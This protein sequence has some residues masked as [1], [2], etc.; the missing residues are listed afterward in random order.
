MDEKDTNR[1]EAFSD[2]VFAVAI[3]LL[4]LDI[5]FSPLDAEKLKD[6][7]AMWSEIGSQWPALFAFI[8]SFCTIGVMW[9]NH[10]RVFK[11]IKHS[12]TT[13]VFI[14]LLLLMIIVFIPVPTNLLAE[15]INHPEYH[16]AAILYG[17]T[18]L[19]MASC[20]SLLW[21]YASHHGRLLGKDV[22]T[23][24][25]NWISRQYAFGPL[26]Y[27]ISIVLAL[28]Y[29]PVSVAFNFLLGIFFALPGVP[30]RRRNRS[31]PLAEKEALSE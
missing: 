7:V 18:F 2:G 5:K 6:D 1:L 29:P 28:V 30:L 19:A 10:H 24:G 27:V 15:Y 22:D 4:V 11:H 25:V 21:R 20:F 23:H 9:L 17:I 26:L 8:T 14:N 31:G 3:T 13:L 12:D 16:T